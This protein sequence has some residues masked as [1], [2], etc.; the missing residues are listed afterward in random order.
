MKNNKWKIENG[1]WK[2]VY[3]CEPSYNDV[4]LWPMLEIA[5]W[6]SQRDIIIYCARQLIGCIH[7]HIDKRVFD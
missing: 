7:C 2:I 1:K 3:D 4:S 6:L 5:L